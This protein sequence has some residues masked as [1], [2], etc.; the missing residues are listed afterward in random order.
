MANVSN[1]FDESS[2]QTKIRNIF[3]QR[4]NDVH[5]LVNQAKPRC[6]NTDQVTAKSCKASW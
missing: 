3:I 1:D 4:Y 2:S 6:C 5:N